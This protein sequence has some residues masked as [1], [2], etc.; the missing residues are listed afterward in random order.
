[1]IRRLI[2]PLTAAVVTLHA[3]QVIRAGRVS[4]AV[5]QQSAGQQRFAFSARERRGAIGFP[6]CVRGV[7]VGRVGP[8]P[9]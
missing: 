1:M 4:G 7:S 9:A 3:G 6:W 8:M 5:A 2:V